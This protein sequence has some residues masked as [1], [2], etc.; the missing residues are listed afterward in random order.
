MGTTVFYAAKGGQGCTVTACAYAVMLAHAGRRV[1]LVDPL[2]DVAPALGMAVMDHNSLREAADGLDVLS[3]EESL[4]GFDVSR[5]DEIV[6]DAGTLTWPDDEGTCRAILVTRSC[7][8]ALRRAVARPV[9]PSRVV[10]IMEDG[11]ALSV[12]DIERTIGAPV[13]AVPCDPAIART[14]DAGLLAGRRLPLS[15]SATLKEIM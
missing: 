10:A 13:T 14:V 1:L 5:Y 7:Y 11:R 15:L 8:L 12:R 2:G 9:E 6:V 3:V 4:R